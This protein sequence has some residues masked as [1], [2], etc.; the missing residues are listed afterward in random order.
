MNDYDEDEGN[1]TFG[2]ILANP[3]QAVNIVWAVAKIGCLLLV[4]A[5]T[6][7]LLWGVFIVGN[8]IYG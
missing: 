2:Y 1:A 7:F 6:C 8:G 5:V 4:I 3:E